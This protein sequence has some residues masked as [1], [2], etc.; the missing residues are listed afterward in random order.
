M[1]VDMPVPL[2]M[3]AVDES[4]RWPGAKRATKK[5]SAA[6]S[7]AAAAAPTELSS[8]FWVLALAQKIAATAT[9]TSV[10]LMYTH[11][12]STTLKPTRNWA[13]ICNA[14][15]IQKHRE[16]QTA[17]RAQSRKIKTKRDDSSDTYS[18]THTLAEENRTWTMH[19]PHTHTAP[20]PPTHT[21]RTSNQEQNAFCC[22]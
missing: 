18:C 16:K 8:S 4:G 3:L 6:T 9:P 1:D 13:H 5:T 11:T 14:G 22:A 20:C 7:Q 19:I 10:L 2:T 21:L 15:Q 17:T 12:C